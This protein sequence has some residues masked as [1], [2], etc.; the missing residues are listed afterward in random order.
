MA[1]LLTLP[2]HLLETITDLLATDVDLPQDLRAELTRATSRL[3]TTVQPETI[4]RTSSDEHLQKLDEE[5]AELIPEHDN[6]MVVAE[7]LKPL[8]IDHDL[9]LSL[10]RW[11]TSDS[12][13]AL[14]ERHNLD[15]SRYVAVS[16]LAGTEVYIPPAELERV[17]IAE[18]PEKPNPFLPAYLS[19]RPPSLGTEYRSLLRNLSTTI[20]IL[21]SIFGSAFAVYV[22]SVSGAG[23]SKETA[24]L[25]AVL[26]GVIVGIADGVLVWIFTGRVKEK[27][28]ERE[29]R[30][31]DMMRGSGAFLDDEDHEEDDEEKN[32]VGDGVSSEIVLE[33]KEGLETTA[34]KKQVQ[35]RRRGLKDTT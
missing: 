31:R 17:R 11:T 19:P 25:L 1:T 16:L 4:E 18:D 13:R 10:S 2:P 20:N 28:K 8:T 15:P 35:L 22:A 30:G 7:E 6:T 26:A 24:I 29:Q 14:L 9:L 32:G 33:K 34:V 5:G 27:R 3:S 23:Y 12:G 21:F